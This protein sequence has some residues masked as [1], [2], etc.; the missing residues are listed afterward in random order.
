[1]LRYSS[2]SA[3]AMAFSKPFAGCSALPDT[4]V[5]VKSTPQ[6]SRAVQASPRSVRQRSVPQAPEASMTHWSTSQAPDL[7][8]VQMSFVVQ[9]PELSDAQQLSL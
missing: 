5:S 8:L 1:M 9:T 3:L 2:R 6:T 7:S 4:M